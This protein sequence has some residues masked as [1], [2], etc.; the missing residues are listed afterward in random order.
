MAENCCSRQLFYYNLSLTQSLVFRA[1]ISYCVQSAASDFD[2]FGSNVL[3]R[4][5]WIYTHSILI[6]LS[7]CT[8]KDI[9]HHHHHFLKARPCF[10]SHINWFSAIFFMPAYH[11][12]QPSSLIVWLSCLDFI[13]NTLP[14]KPFWRNQSCL[15]ASNFLFQIKF[16]HSR[17]IEMI[18]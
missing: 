2:S 11:A 5:T 9:I 15:S 13:P 1:D 17:L 4:V 3:Q 8:R 6:I 10:C 7:H 12:A 16:Y 18:S 14:S